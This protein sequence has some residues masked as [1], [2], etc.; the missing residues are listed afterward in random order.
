[1]T[2]P[3]PDR[4]GDD[5]AR[6]RDV[7]TE[8]L[9]AWR[10]GDGGAV[11]RLFPLVYEEL[12]RIA[13]RQL[14]NE[15]PGHTLSTTAV[16]HEAYLDLV[17]QR[18]QWV[19]RA[20]FFGVAAFVMRRVLLEYARAH[21]AAKRGGGVSHL[22][23][24]DALEASADD[25]ADMLIAIDDALTRMAAIDPRLARVV[26]CRF[27]GGLTAAETAEVL[28]VTERTVERDWVK[29]K[30]LLAHSLEP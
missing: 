11:D 13:H 18:A 2:P 3:T 12:R 14:R 24:D 7:V 19:D 21:H 26:E 28:G 6:P 1:V 5:E 23:L 17:K 29:A 22:T 16:V 20:H 27:F 4:E 10:E 15:R 9:L 25:R 30:A 8:A